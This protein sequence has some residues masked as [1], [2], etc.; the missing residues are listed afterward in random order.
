MN[1]APETSQARFDGRADCDLSEPPRPRSG[2]VHEVFGSSARAFAAALASRRI[3]EGP[4]R[5]VLWIGRLRGAA[6]LDPYGLAPFLDP[7]SLVFV[8]ARKPLDVLWTM[9][10]ALR[11]DGTAAVI[12]ELEQSLELTASRRLQL[13]AAEG[14]ALALAITQEGRAPRS[15]AVETRWRVAAVSSGRAR[16]DAPTWR[17]DLVKNKHGRTG[18]WLVRWRRRGARRFAAQ[19]L[20][21]DGVMDSWTSPHHP[22]RL[23]GCAGRGRV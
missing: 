2:R 15:N 18:A 16:F 9:E 11:V 4:K 6:A 19:R 20:K 22:S 23:C 14:S 7:G 10:Q 8:E 21:P 1:V 17:C 12:C 3:A 13:A 5:P